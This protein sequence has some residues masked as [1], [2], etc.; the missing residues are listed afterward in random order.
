MRESLEE[1]ERQRHRERQEQQRRSKCERIGSERGTLLIKIRRFFY[2]N[3][4]L[5][6]AI[7]DYTDELLRLRIS[8]Q[9]SQDDGGI[10]SRID[11][12]KIR[13][14]QARSELQQLEAEIERGNNQMSQLRSKFFRNGCY[15]WFDPGPDD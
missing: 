5:N 15:D 7:E 6:D 10:S 9:T 2:A 12:L 3:N 13:R 14:E 11:S 4:D 8:A 1:D